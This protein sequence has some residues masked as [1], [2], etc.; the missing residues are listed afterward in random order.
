MRCGRFGR[1]FGRVQTSPVDLEPRSGQAAK[2]GRSLG[3]GVAR[4]ER[5]AD[6]TAGTRRISARP[7]LEQGNSVVGYFGWLCRAFSG[8]AC[9]GL[10]VV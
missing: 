8:P 1:P 9:D 4:P 6:L 10:I 3:A 5:A 2:Q 7:V